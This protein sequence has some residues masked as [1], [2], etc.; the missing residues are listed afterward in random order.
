MTDFKELAIEEALRSELGK[1]AVFGRHQ[2]DIRT[3]MNF[4][5]DEAEKQMGP[6]FSVYWVKTGPPDVFCLSGFSPSPVVFS[7][8]YLSLTA[9]IRHLFVDDWLKNMLV[10]VAERTTL[11]LMAEM[12]LWQGDPDYSVL[13][14]VKSM[15][16]KGIYLSDDDQL[17]DLEYAPVSEA[18]MA[19]WFYA[20]VHE[21]GHLNP[22]HQQNFPTGHLFSDEAILNAITVK[23]DDFPYYSPSMRQEAVELAKQSGSKSVLAIDH[24]RSEGLADMFAASVLLQAASNI[25]RDIRKPF[26]IP[27]FIQ[28]LIIFFNIIAVIDRCTRVASIASAR[29]ADREARF[30]LALQPVALRVRALMQHHYL[31]SAITMFLH[32]SD[33]TMEQYQRVVTMINGINK[34]NAEIINAVDSGLARAMEFSLFPERRENDRALLEAFL[35]DFAHSGPGIQETLRFCKMADAIRAESKLL[36]ALKGIVSD[37]SKSC[38]RL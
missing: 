31:D 30:E 13:A 16:G 17:M 19:T 32:G 10:E 27:Q 22:D 23:L 20:L 26:S 4:V 33:Y 38:H 24:V 9:F 18:Y 2:R 6:Q 3:P 15:T 37:S 14:F 28:E 25:M 8:R 35:K 29:T 12:A 36:Q 7:S 21:L 1:T 11:K 5:L 34:T